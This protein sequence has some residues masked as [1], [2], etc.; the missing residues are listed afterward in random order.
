[1]VMKV[2]VVEDEPLIAMLMQRTLQAWGLN[3]LG[4]VQTAEKAIAIAEETR[5]DAALLDINLGREETSLPAADNLRD[6]GVPFAFVSGYQDR[7]LPERFRAAPR[8]SKP[9]SDD[10]LRRTLQSFGVFED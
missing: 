4:P 3:I 7:K 6:Q 9:V 10:E 1:M 8:L 5:P 2:L